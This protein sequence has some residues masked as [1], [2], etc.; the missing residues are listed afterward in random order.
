MIIVR[1]GDELI[2]YELV[3]D[4]KEKYFIKSLSGKVTV[5][6]VG[7]LE[8]KDVD[9]VMHQFFSVP[10]HYALDKDIS[11]SEKKCILLSIIKAQKLRVGI[12]DEDYNC[13]NRAIHLEEILNYY[14]EYGI[15]KSQTKEVKKLTKGKIDW[16]KTVKKSVPYKQQSSYVYLDLFRKL[17]IETDNI[18]TDS[19]LY[20]LTES[21]KEYEF[22]F[23]YPNLEQSYSLNYDN[24]SF[25]ISKLVKISNE[26]FIDREIKLLNHI[27]AFF[28]DQTHNSVEKSFVT[29]N[30]EL[31]FEEM[32]HEHLNKY[33]PP[34][35]K[36]KLNINSLGNHKIEI[37]HFSEKLR[38]IADSKYYK[39]SNDFVDYK[40]L[41]Y[42]FHIQSMT[43]YKGV[44]FSNILIKPTT[45]EKGISIGKSFEHN[46]FKSGNNLHTYEVKV[47][48]KELIEE[49]S[50][51][52]MTIGL[53]QKFNV[54]A[55]F[56]I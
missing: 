18:I 44:T 43:E 47:P 9:S 7:F 1:D 31:V 13:V 24:L 26:I 19:M 23:D 45:S 46:N 30:Y 29:R 8:Y 12:A 27:I 5:N 15:Y 34:F 41:F 2:D 28:K 42:Q 50:G 33:N 54:E 48:I 55:K 36:K 25:I 10:K 52:D 11:H 56:M 20:I 37:D 38:I 3:N 4:I 16:K 51:I 14:N 22:Y 17:S 40:Q 49:F 32:I 6:F 53:I 35:V 21:I 39:S